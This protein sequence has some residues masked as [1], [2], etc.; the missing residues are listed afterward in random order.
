MQT[1]GR[2]GW[3]TGGLALILRQCSHVLQKTVQ[4]KGLRRSGYVPLAK[5]D[6]G[7]SPVFNEELNLLGIGD[8][9]PISLTTKLHPS[10]CLFGK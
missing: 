6:G 4:E 5:A 8:R 1:C 2:V 10:M 7:L 3:K 9:Q